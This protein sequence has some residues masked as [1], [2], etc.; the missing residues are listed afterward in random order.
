L[1]SICDRFLRGLMAFAQPAK[2][3]EMTDRSVII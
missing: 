3:Y 1:L 2:S